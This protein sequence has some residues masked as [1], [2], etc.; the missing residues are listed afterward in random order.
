[1]D[2][3]QPL[4]VA[5][6][7]LLLLGRAAPLRAQTIASAE[8]L[9]RWVTAVKTHVPGKADAAAA[10]VASLGY[11][12]RLELDPA[13]RKFL[14]SIRGERLTANDQA[15]AKLAALLRS[16]KEDPG[17]E[18]F[19]KRAVLLHTDAAVFGD[20][21]RPPPDDAPATTWEPGRG[22]RRSDPP[23][24]LLWSERFLLTRD[25]QVLGDI[26]ISWQLVFAR[27]LVDPRPLGLLPREDDF[28]AEWY[29]AVAAYLFASGLNGDVTGHFTRAQ[30]LFP[31][32]ARLLFDRACYAEL[33]GLPIYQ[34]VSD[35]RGARGQVPSEDKTN[36]EAERLYR[37]VLDVDPG[38]VEARVRLARLL[39]HRGQPEE[40]AAEIATALE[41]RTPGI[42]G[43]YAHIVAGRIASA[44]GRYDEALAQYRDALALFGNA[45]SALLGESHAALMGAEV[46]GTLAPIARLGAAGAAD[47]AD[48]WRDYHLGAGRDLDALMAHLWARVSR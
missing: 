48:P 4:A 21:F 30:R 31:N 41:A 39:N 33:L 9:E 1:M 16:V 2:T 13:M 26:P 29:H 46:A 24:P 43:F 20:R 25:G 18:P 42:V 3:R 34:T 12:S 22:A 36:A 10:S 11:R 5:V 38:F 6:A 44:R 8:A 14:A 23:S 45:Q 27:S 28:I 19:V 37:R 15:A 32:D 35:D 17:I 47:N 40:A 7:A